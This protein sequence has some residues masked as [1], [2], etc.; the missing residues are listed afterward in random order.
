MNLTC[1]AKCWGFTERMVVWRRRE[2][3]SGPA[4]IGSACRSTTTA[5]RVRAGGWP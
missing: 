2:V 5:K 1:W 3:S 4:S